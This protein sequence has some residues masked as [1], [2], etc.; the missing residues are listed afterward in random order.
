MIEGLAWPG[1][2]RGSC[3]ALCVSGR[4]GLFVGHGLAC[5]DFAGSSRAEGERNV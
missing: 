5:F 1:P 4:K 2:L 3:L